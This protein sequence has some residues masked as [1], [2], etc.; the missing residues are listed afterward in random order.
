MKKIEFTREEEAVIVR[1]IQDYFG[2]E[3]EQDIGQMGAKLLLD[4]FSEKIGAYYYNRGLYDAQA[5]LVSKLDD[6]TDA[7]YAIEK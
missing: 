3:L 7:I 2:E 1:H 5:I 6:I 4:F